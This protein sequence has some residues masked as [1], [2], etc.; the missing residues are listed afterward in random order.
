MRHLSFLTRR[1]VPA[2]LC[3]GIFWPAAAHEIRPAIVNLTLASDRYEIEIS[4]NME[5]LLAGVSPLHADTE[6]SP[7][8]RAY[9]AL[10]ALPPKDLERRI[11]EFAPRFLDGIRLEFDDARAAPALVAVMV[12]EAGDLALARLTRLRLAGALPAGARSVR[13]SYAEK[14][15]ASILRLRRPNDVNITAAWLKPGAQ[16]ERYPLA[17]A[18]R[19]RGWPEVARDYLA[20]GFTHIVPKGLDHILFVL[21][22]FLLS[23]R[24]QPLLAQVTAFTV[25]HSITLALTMLGIFSL[26]PAIV[27]PLIAASIAYVAVENI[28]TSRLQPWRLAVVFGFGLL[29]GMGFAGVL[30]EIGLPRG[31]FLTGLIAFN[32]GVECG[33]LTVI[34]LAFILIRSW[35]RDKPWY[36]RRVMV[37]ASAAIALVGLYWTVERLL[38]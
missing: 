24:W 25:A 35:S 37:P 8:A 23:T 16:S 2:L 32:V 9:N 21:G 18:L 20:L 22:L 34:A 26:S 7:N 10:R 19:V 6:E 13:W 29:H 38:A 14:F 5:A 17:G 31:E 36:R 3:L 28:L 4:A 1:I 11:R 15:G 12:P 30:Q 27:E 33:Q